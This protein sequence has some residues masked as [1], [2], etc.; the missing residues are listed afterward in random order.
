MQVGERAR[1]VLEEIAREVEHLEV[2]KRAKAAR[3]LRDFVAPKVEFNEA[4]QS[5][6]G[7][8]YASAQPR[9]RLMR[10]INHTLSTRSQS[11]PAHGFVQGSVV[12]V[13]SI[14]DE[15]P[16]RVDP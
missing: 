7:L 8:G 12:V 4:L 9:P 3:N 5:A 10:V 1:D 14:L 16:L 2:S 15:P 6:E 11:T 13:R